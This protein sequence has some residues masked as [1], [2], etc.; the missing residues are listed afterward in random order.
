MTYTI[1]IPLTPPSGNTWNRL[2]YHDQDDLVND[3][4]PLVSAAVGRAGFCLC[5]AQAAPAD[6]KARRGTGGSTELDHNPTG[7]TDEPIAEAS[8]ATD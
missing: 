2:H 3:W 5:L 6:S 1:S 8:P 7:R 4:R